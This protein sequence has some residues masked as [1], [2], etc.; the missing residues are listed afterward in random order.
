[1]KA[2]NLLGLA[3]AFTIIVLFP[4][5]SAD[6]APSANVSPAAAEVA[7]LASSGVGDDI[8]LGY[9]KNAQAPFKLSADDILY[10]KNK[11]VSSAVITAMLSHDS[12]AKPDAQPATAPAPST[13]T[14][15]PASETPDVQTQTQKNPPPEVAYFYEKL[16]PYGV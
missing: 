13:S 5:H 8:V 14:E 3:A 4:A 2:V 10:L 16:A 15:A 1:M 6:T 9:I 12:G 11:G 7:R